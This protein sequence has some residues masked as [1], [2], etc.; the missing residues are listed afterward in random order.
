MKVYK[1][2]KY[3]IKLSKMKDGNSTKRYVELQI[4][5]PRKQAVR[6]VLNPSLHVIYR[7]KDIMLLKG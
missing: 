3:K 1:K 5:A 2:K 7:G 6:S 4:Y